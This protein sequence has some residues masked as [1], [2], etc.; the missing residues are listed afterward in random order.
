MVEINHNPSELNQWGDTTEKQMSNIIFYRGKSPM[1]KK[2]KF[3]FYL[4]LFRSLVYDNSYDHLYNDDYDWW[5][6]R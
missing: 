3:V 1:N 6:E 4:F 5:N 2:N